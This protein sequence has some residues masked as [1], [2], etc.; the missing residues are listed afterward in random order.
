M[1]PAL[2]ALNAR[3]AGKFDLAMLGESLQLLVEIRQLD[4]K[5]RLVSQ[6]VISKP[7]SQMTRL[8]RSLVKRKPKPYDHT[9]TGHVGEFLKTMTRAVE[10]FLDRSVYEYPKAVRVC[11]TSSEN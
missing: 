11:F 1:N 10:E 6:Q 5:Q 4:A 9:E 2:D 7:V 8:E 3:C